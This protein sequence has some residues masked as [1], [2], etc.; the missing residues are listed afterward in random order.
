MTACWVFPWRDRRDALLVQLPSAYDYYF[1][2]TCSE[3]VILEFPAA[4]P[5]IHPSRL[6]HGELYMP[7]SVSVPHIKPEAKATIVAPH[8]DKLLDRGLFAVRHGE[9]KDAGILGLPPS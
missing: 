2:A 1:F 9:S 3:L 4:A 5:A 8:F 7:T 6:L